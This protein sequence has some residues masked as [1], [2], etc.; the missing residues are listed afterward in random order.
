MAFFFFL[1]YPPLYYYSRKPERYDGMVRLRRI[2]AF[3]S[4][5]FGGIVFKFEFE[6][7]IDWQK[8]YIICPHHTSNLDTA[9]ISL[10]MKTDKFCFMGKEELKDGLVT[11]I[12]FRTVDLPVDRNNK[13]S[14]F[15]AFKKAA[16]KLNDGISMIMFP[17]GGIADDFPPAVQ[18]FKNGPF[19]LAIEQQVPIIP[20][21]SLTT[22][23]ILWDDGLKY[24]SRPGV[25]RVFVHKPIETTG[26]SVAHADA[27]R[28]EVRQI[29]EKKF[30]NWPRRD[31]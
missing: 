29:I 28:D 25:C 19:R 16:N 11:G 1:L 13:I 23:K 20:V 31:E 14:A 10:L 15:R 2:W 30:G 18:E 7:P 6:E 5:V 3:L 12:Y 8:T 4:T 26:S 27:L 22:W 9:M 21:T 17:E 24:G